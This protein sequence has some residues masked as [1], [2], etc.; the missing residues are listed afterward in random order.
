MKRRALTLC[1]GLMLLGLTPGSTFAS[2]PPSDFDQ[3][4]YP[5]NTS[6]QFSAGQG[7]AQTFT[8]GKSGLLVG[9]SLD[10]GSD[11]PSAAV[12]S[13]YNANASGPQGVALATSPSM[14]VPG[15]P[16]WISFSVSYAVTA[17]SMYAIVVGPTSNL[18]AVGSANNYPGGAAY[19]VDSNVWTP[20]TVGVPAAPAD[21]GFED[22]IDQV[23][24]TIG[25]DKPSITAGTTTS[26]TLSTT[27]TYSAGSAAQNFRAVLLNVPGWF[28]PQSIACTVQDGNSPP[29]MLAPIYCTV[30]N[31]RNGVAGISGT[32][33]PSPN[34][35][36]FRYNITGS[37]APLLADAATPGVAGDKAC[38][39][40]TQA[41]PIISYCF[42]A[43][44]SVAVAA[45]AATPTPTPTPVP[46]VAP[47]PTP[48]PTVAPTPTPAPTAAPTPTP[49]PAPTAAPTPTPVPTPAPTITPPPTGTAAGSDRD[50]TGGPGLILPLAMLGL[51]G[52][53]ILADRRHRRIL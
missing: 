6:N 48:V 28:T 7:L 9:F 12:A 30:D 35:E 13:L 33:Y 19:V 31:L 24:A 23:T 44:A 17:G 21:F 38:I 50:N 10:L 42:T 14:T 37:G 51:V 22:Y 53:L 29:I 41:P 36:T 27:M 47:T 15:N 25:W 32:N 52:G 39:E 11:G 43:A 45:P 8:A 2:L 26:L 5:P 3:S 4:N 18:M 40:Y 16:S 49:T 46:T 20:A 34:V 1:A